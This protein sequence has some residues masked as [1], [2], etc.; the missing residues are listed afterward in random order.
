MDTWVVKPF[1]GI[2]IL[3]NDGGGK[4]NKSHSHFL[5]GAHDVRVADLDGDGDKDLVASA[6]YY[7]ETGLIRP[8][9]APSIVWLERG[10]DGSYTSHT[11]E[12]SKSMHFS[13][14]IGDL[15]ADGDLDIIAANSYLAT[16]PARDSQAPAPPASAPHWF[17]HFENRKNP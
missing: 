7:Q 10:P 17:N 14:D 8:D 13:L 1:Q 12:T 16:M 5:P 4:F 3:D 11:L 6:A 15:D 2:S 9:S